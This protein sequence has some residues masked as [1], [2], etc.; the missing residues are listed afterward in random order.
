MGVCEMMQTSDDSGREPVRFKFKVLPWACFWLATMEIFGL[1]MGI[2]WIRQDGV[3]GGLMFSTVWCLILGLFGGIVI[4]GASDIIVD[5][6]RISR[7]LF[8]WIW[9]AFQWD[10]IGK[11]VIR[12]VM[13]PYSNRKRTIRAFAIYRRSLNGNILSR[14]WGMSFLERGEHMQ[15]LIRLLNRYIAAHNIKI[16]S[17]SNGIKTSVG[18]L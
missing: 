2:I 16:E 12:R 4:Q 11:V 17:E 13:D 10:S 3:L 14:W 8:G 7:S 15:E 6:Q 1:V 18:N 5:D 9:Q